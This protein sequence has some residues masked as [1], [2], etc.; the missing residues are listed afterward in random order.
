[1]ST[2]PIVLL[3]Q[4]GDSTNIVYNA[5]ARS[6][7]VTGVVMEAE[8]PKRTL[9]SRRVKKLGL[10]TVIGQLAFRSVIVPPLARASQARIRQICEQHGLSREPIPE[11][12]I[13]RVPSVNSTEACARLA[14]LGP[15]LVVVNGTRIISK[16]TLGAVAVP[17]VNTHVG[18][19][20]LY[21]GVHG[22]YWA[23]AQ[24]DAQH[25]GV[26]VHLV[27]T[28]I[29]TGSILGQATIEPTRDDNFV[30]YP[31]L[32]YAHAVPLLR[33]GIRA[34]LSGQ[35]R[36]RAAPSGT[37]RLWSHPTI[38]EYLRNRLAGVR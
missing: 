32:Q 16:D 14:S 18:I 13:Q 5:L 15:A 37:S 19:T 20:P 33:D 1:M 6:F 17:F 21:R 24:K 27:D 26:T 3:A 7:N 25:C 30:T 23:L 9:L 35:A 4:A 36:P 28:G 29:D 22:G 2:Q 38:G 10:R 31:Y 34:L 8:V 12:L 11:A